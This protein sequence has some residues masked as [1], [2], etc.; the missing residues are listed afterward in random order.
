MKLIFQCGFWC[1]CWI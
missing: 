1:C